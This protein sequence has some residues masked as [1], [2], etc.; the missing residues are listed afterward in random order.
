[1]VTAIEPCWTDGLAIW[2]SK[3]PCKCNEMRGGCHWTSHRDGLGTAEQMALGMAWE[4]HGRCSVSIDS[5]SWV[6]ARVG[7]YGSGKAGEVCAG[8][9]QGR[10]GTGQGLP[11]YGRIR[12]RRGTGWSPA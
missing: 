5:G 4:W 8:R 1:M 10:Q 12:S 9:R 3:K 6:Q 7:A 2:H 11:V